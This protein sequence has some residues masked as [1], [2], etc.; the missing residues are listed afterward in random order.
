[1]GVQ[2]ARLA[3]LVRQLDVLERMTEDA[4]A[5]PRDGSARYHFD[6]PRLRDDLQRI[7]QG[8]RAYLSPERAQPRDAMPMQADYRVE[9]E[10]IDEPEQ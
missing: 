10:A 6:Y 3:A 2:E 8:I 7:R 5:L 1:M 9:T 4:A